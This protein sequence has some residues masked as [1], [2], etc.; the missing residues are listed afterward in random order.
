MDRRLD[1]H[2]E[3]VPVHG[4]AEVDQLQQG[5]VLVLQHYVL[6]LKKIKA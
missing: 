6:R 4:T 1:A 2:V 3:V 5:A